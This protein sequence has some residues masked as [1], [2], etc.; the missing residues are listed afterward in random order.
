V[1]SRILAIALV[2]PLAVLN[3]WAFANIFAYFRSL[4]VVVLFASLLSFL[5]NYPVSWLEE[6]GIGA[7]RCGNIGFLAGTGFTTG[8]WGYP[9]APCPQ[10]SSTTCGSIT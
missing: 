6:A 3:A 1:M 8:C 5:L 7:H 9:C 2:A 4:L 10:S